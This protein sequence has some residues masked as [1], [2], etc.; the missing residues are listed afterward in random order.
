M[1]NVLRQKSLSVFFLLLTVTCLSTLSGCESHTYKGAILEDE[2]RRLCREEYGINNVQVQIKGKTLGVYLPLERL[3]SANLDSMSGDS[4]EKKFEDLFKFDEEAEERVHNVLFSISRIVLSTDRDIDFY[5]LRAVET[6]KTGIE[7]MMTGYV[8]DTKKV[9]HWYI[10]ISEYRKRF[11]QDLSINQSIV[12]RRTVKDFFEHVGSMEK[13]DLISAYFVKGVALKDISPF[14]YSQIL[15]AEYKN[16]L[17]YHFN[18]IKSKP[19]SETSTLVYVSLNET[20]TSAP[21]DDFLF[22]SGVDH[23]YLFVLEADRAAFKIRQVIPFYYI[24]DE[25]NVKKLDFP[26]EMSIYKN[27]DN[28]SDEFELEEITMGM[29]LARQLTKRLNT[30]IQ[31]GDERFKGYNTAKV[32]LDY[33]ESSPDEEGNILNKMILTVS[34]GGSQMGVNASSADESVSKSAF[35]KGLFDEIA[36]VV[37]SYQFNDFDGIE[38]LTFPDLKQAFVDKAV[39]AEYSAKKAEDRTISTL[40]DLDSF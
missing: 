30:A 4:S 27:I 13:E 18:T 11:M 19:I 2:V 10:P 22:Q 25:R 32:A 15:E 21:E 7:L 12:W 29:F 28:W 36:Y 26:D 14:F 6:E 1:L 17:E 3:F 39:F 20:Y 9:R 16:N 37:E 40:I 33:S 38:F 23:E 35:V 5:V 31:T 34:F 24:D 8:D